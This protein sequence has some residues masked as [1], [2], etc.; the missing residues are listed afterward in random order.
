MRQRE[1]PYRQLLDEPTV[2]EGR[3]RAEAIRDEA[4]VPDTMSTHTPAAALY[5]CWETGQTLRQRLDTFMQYED[6]RENS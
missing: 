4:L 5:A 2:L 3:D 1:N 6:F